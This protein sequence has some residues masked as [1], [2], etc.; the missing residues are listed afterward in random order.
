ME[1]E[2][3]LL[4]KE[5]IEIFEK[6]GFYVPIHPSLLNESATLEKSLAK[7]VFPQAANEWYQDLKRYVEELQD[8][9]ERKWIRDVFLKKNHT[10]KCVIRIPNMQ[11]RGLHQHIGQMIYSM[12]TTVLRGLCR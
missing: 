3:I 8:A 2:E 6:T 11:N 9:Q 4:K 7:K 12:Q 10:L 5:E 1:L